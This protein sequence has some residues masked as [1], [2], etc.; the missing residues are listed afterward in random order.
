M[1]MFATAVPSF[2]CGFEDPSSATLQRGVLNWVYPKSLY[3]STAVWQAQIAGIVAKDRPLTGNLAGL[4][5]RR[6]QLL[7]RQLEIQTAAAAGARP[8]PR[9]SVVLLGP[10]LWTSYDA[11]S[12][13]VKA[14]LHA[15]GPTPGDVVVVTDS[16]V[17][18]ALLTGALTVREAS[19]FGLIRFYGDD[20]D[21]ALLA[22][23]LDDLKP[24]PRRTASTTTD[25]GAKIPKVARAIA[26]P[27]SSNRPS[28][29]SE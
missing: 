14:S 15:A 7:M 3:V 13:R 24:V 9:F 18:S 27:E 19:D 11:A 23:V 25:S 8:V 20:A 1:M 21:I 10:M 28:L 6:A 4:G 5:L 17:V 2:A 26:V 16:V 12:G 29:Q 22:H